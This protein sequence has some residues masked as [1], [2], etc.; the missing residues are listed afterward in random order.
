[1]ARINLYVGRAGRKGL[2]SGS[3]RFGAAAKAIERNHKICRRR[4]QDRIQVEGAARAYDRV[5]VLG[6]TDENGGP[7]G[8]ARGKIRR[9]VRN[10]HQARVGFNKASSR[11]VYKGAKMQRIDMVGV[12]GQDRIVQVLRFVQLARFMKGRGTIEAV[13]TVH[14]R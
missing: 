6:K 8:M 10:T 2:T 5:F 3:D 11:K 13:L 1:V 12:L 7:I 9:E 14:A 4:K